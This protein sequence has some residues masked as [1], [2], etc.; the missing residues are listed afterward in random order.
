MNIIQT[1]LLTS[2][3][4]LAATS[5]AAAQ[6]N[7]SSTDGKCKLLECPLG[8]K[9]VKEREAYKQSVKDANAAEKKATSQQK[10]TDDRC[11]QT[12]GNTIRNVINDPYAAARDI[13]DGRP[14]GSS[15]CDTEKDKL[16]ALQDKAAAAQRQAQAR[17]TEYDN[18]KKR[19]GS[20]R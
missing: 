5:H 15:Q 3:I 13:S 17:K 16:A 2:A 10:V 19:T 6:G 18:A 12:A 9:T 11:A 14:I 8:T 7:R 1:V 4:W 20:W